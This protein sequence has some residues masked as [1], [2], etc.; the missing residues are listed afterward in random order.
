M[1][2]I[3]SLIK[4]TIKDKGLLVKWVAAEMP[5]S[6][7]NLYDIF[8]KQSIDMELL[9]RFSKVIGHNWNLSI[10]PSGKELKFID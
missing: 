2:H 10:N 7:D 9:H 5:M 6:R 4:K 8:K 1:V 3:G